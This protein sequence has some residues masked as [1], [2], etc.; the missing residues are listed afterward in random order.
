MSHYRTRQPRE[1][2]DSILN[3]CSVEYYAVG[4]YGRHS[5]A[6]NEAAEEVCRELLPVAMALPPDQHPKRRISHG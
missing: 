5:V 4:A 3:W 6:W 1:L 2:L